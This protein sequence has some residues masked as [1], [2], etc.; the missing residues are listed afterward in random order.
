MLNYFR[1]PPNRKSVMTQTQTD[2]ATV[3]TAVENIY[4]HSGPAV[5]FEGQAM[6]DL[7]ES[8]PDVASAITAL[9]SAETHVAFI[10]FQAAT[11]QQGA[12]A[13]A[14]DLTPP[15]PTQL[16]LAPI[17]AQSGPVGTPIAAIIPTASGGTAPYAFT[18]TG[19]P[20]GL[21]FSGTKISG[22]PTAAGTSTV[23]VSVTDSGSPAQKASETVVITVSAVTP[24][25]PPPTGKPPWGEYHAGNYVQTPSIVLDYGDN[26]AT[27]YSFS[28]ARTAYLKGKR[29]MLKMGVLTQ[30][31]CTALGTLLV[32]NGQANA[33]IPWMWEGNQGVN[34]WENSWNENA[35][36]AAQFITQFNNQCAWMRAVNGAKFL[37][38]YC[39]NVNQVGNQKTGRTQTDTFPGAGVN[40]DV[41][42]APDGYDNPG[43]TGSGAAGV[44]AQ[45]APFEQLASQKGVAFAGFCECGNNG[46]DDPTYWTDLLNHAE[47]NGYQWITNFQATTQQGGSFN[48]TTGPNSIAAIKAFYAS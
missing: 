28:S 14:A 8:P 12:T 7:Q 25:P 44:I 27:T 30:A 19:L 20:A 48:S 13:L 37:F 46:S 31:Q 41:V 1:D 32:A 21:S 47:A 3:A 5:T 9:Q 22:T 34:G 36:T 16:V 2:L 6:A 17:A 45:A 40:G 23:T 33:I 35:F 38:A 29:L 15:P 11:A 26:N 10:A 39:P 42:I 24:P 43:D 4:E 18:V